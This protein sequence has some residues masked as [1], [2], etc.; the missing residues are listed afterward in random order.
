VTAVADLLR[1]A[2]RDRL[3]RRLAEWRDLA[4]AM[5]QPGSMPAVPEPPALHQMAAAAASAT[6]T[7]DARPEPPGGSK[8]RNTM[9]EPSEIRPGDRVMLRG[10]LG[11]GLVHDA[12]LIRRPPMIGPHS[13]A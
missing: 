10:K 9:T 7:T 5:R 8:E 6:T 11:R 4:D 3:L 2:D 13:G 1:S 12:Y